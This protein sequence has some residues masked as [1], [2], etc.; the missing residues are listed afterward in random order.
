MKVIDF[1]LVKRVG[2]EVGDGVLLRGTPVCMALK[3]VARGEYESPVDI[4]GVAVGC[5]VVEMITGKPAW[6]G[7]AGAIDVNGCCFKLDLAMNCWRFH[8]NC[9]RKGRISCR[10]AL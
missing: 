10:G 5:A 1:G 2:E 8:W 4:W 3:A 6:P 7:V 9:Q